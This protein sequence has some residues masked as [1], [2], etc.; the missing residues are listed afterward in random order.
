MKFANLIQVC[1]HTSNCGHTFKCSPDDDDEACEVLLRIHKQSLDVDG[2]V[3]LGK[4][5]MDVSCRN[6]ACGV[7]ED[8]LPLTLCFH[9]TWQEIDRCA[10]V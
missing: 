9:Q 3:H 5:E 1:K 10:K 2:E 6:Y 4:D 7:I 8:C